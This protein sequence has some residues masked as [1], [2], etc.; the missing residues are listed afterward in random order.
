[1]I[2]DVKPH[3]KDSKPM[4]YLFLPLDQVFGILRGNGSNADLFSVSH[5]CTWNSVAPRDRD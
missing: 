5:G 4:T 3:V 1:M 2:D